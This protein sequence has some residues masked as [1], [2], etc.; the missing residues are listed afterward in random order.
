MQ[1]RPSREESRLRGASL[2][3]PPVLPGRM[4]AVHPCGTAPEPFQ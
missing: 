2:P 3:W 4:S 1:G